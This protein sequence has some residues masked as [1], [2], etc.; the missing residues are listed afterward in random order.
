MNDKSKY[1]INKRDHERYELTI[2][3]KL[4][5]DGPEPCYQLKNEFHY[6]ECNEQEFRENFVRL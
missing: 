1:Y 2:G 6:H 4:G 5:A 3:E